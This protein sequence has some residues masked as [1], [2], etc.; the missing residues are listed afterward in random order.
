MRPRTEARPRRWGVRSLLRSLWARLH[1]GTPGVHALLCRARGRSSGLEFHQW[2]EVRAEHPDRAEAAAREALADW[3]GTLI[4]VEAWE[5]ARRAFRPEDAALIATSRVYRDAGRDGG[6]GVF[7]AD[8][9][10][11]GGDGD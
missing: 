9:C 5:P 10:D 1:G 2:V 8:G 7:A 11:G 6:G 3:G 4:A